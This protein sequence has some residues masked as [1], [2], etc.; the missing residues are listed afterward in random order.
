MCNRCVTQI[1]DFVTTPNLQLLYPL[2]VCSKMPHYSICTAHR[3]NRGQTQVYPRFFSPMNYSK[4]SAQDAIKQYTKHKR[5]RK[6]R[7]SPRGQ[8]T[9]K[10]LV[11]KHTKQLHTPTHKTLQIPSNINRNNSVWFL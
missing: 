3:G 9:N 8:G 2:F 4:I 7:Q 1:S 10:T 5:F 6:R 11:K